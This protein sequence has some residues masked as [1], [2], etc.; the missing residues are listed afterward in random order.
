MTL[1]LNH[2]DLSTKVRRYE[3]IRVGVT[4]EQE[5]DCGSDGLHYSWILLDSAGWVFPLP[6]IDTHRQTLTLP[7]YLLDYDIYTAV[8]K[9]QDC[10]FLT[11]IS[12]CSFRISSTV[13][14]LQWLCYRFRSHTVW[15]TVT[16]VWECRWYRVPPSP[17]FKGAPTSLWA[18]TLWYHW[19]GRNP[20]TQTSPWTQ[21]GR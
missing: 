14:C 2:S 15:C 8:A 1:I 18:G 9:V 4:Y 16:T 13:A 11:R 6:A 21:S 5:F 10:W 7:G 12:C 19:M 17:P 20:M 3:V